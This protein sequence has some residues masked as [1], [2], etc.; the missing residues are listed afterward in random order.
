MARLKLCFVEWFKTF[1]SI[2][3]FD[4]KIF[5]ALWERVYPERSHLHADQLTN[6][7]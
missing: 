3:L 7:S 5:G 6:Y 2:C 1:I 4:K